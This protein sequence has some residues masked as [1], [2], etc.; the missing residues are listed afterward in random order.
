M[1]SAVYERMRSNPKF[2]ELVRTRGRY[3]WTLAVVVLALFYGFVLMVA[4]KPAIVG[5]HLS[6]GSVL[7]IGVAY[8]LF[9]FAF[10]WIL[11]ALYVRRANGEFDA[12]TAEII[13]EA[14]ADAA[15]QKEAV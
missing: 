5:Q 7:S 3:A 9:M 6:E 15:A 13:A 8:G 1:S 10:F 11:T 14:K 12:K 4:F 2:Q